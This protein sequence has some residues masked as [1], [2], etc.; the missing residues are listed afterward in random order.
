MTS[1]SSRSS[2]LAS[3]S[4]SSSSSMTTSIASRHVG[5]TRAGSVY[6]GAG[7]SGT[8]ISQ[9]FLSSSA[10]TGG[11]A[12]TWKFANAVDVSDN[13]KVSMQNLN[14]CLASY[15]EKVRSLER[16]NSELEMKIRRFLESKAK[17]EGHDCS[18]F[19]A[20][21]ADLQD[22]FLVATQGNAAII[23]A[24]DNA[25]LATDDFRVKYEN[26]LSV[27][28]SVE[29]DIAGLRRVL[30]ELSLARNDLEIQ[31]ESLKE[32]LIML[33]RN[34]DDD[35]LALRSQVGGQ[36]SVEV[37]A[38]PQQDLA[39]I[40]AG[41]REH[42]ENVATKNRRDL[43]N[44][45]QAKT[46][47]LNKEVALSSETLRTS[48]S[49]ITE[50]R[51]TVQMLEIKLQ[52]QISKKAALEA[53]L[54]ES[55]SRYGGVLSGRQRRVEALEE[56]LVR[57]RED[58]EQQRTMYVELLDIKTRLEL[59]IAEYRRLL[60]RDAK[61]ITTTKVV[62]IVQEVDESGNVLTTTAS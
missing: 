51:Q 37:D 35:L 19:K 52:A 11:V 47:E 24:I 14:D 13:K 18:A 7:G 4:S 2:Y 25:K 60:D 36:V 16:A 43:D 48:K 61:S 17:P 33:K 32:E 12:A 9:A 28:Q 8:R 6:G 5:V 1:F 22:Q 40:M 39:S 38:A 42:Y 54:A 45:F 10:P 29:A 34:H 31:L 20:V 3:S 62:T 57:L 58:L 21:I 59:E 53:T 44:W 26:E 50:V 27:R 56:Q 49:E 15:L 41:I 30:D 23:L 46:A 55:S